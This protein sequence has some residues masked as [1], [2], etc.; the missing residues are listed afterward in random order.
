MRSTAQIELSENLFGNV[1]R[2][3]PSQR[4]DSSYEHVYANP[5]TIRA[6]TCNEREMEERKLSGL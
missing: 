5:E 6:Q 2:G 4:R 3:D 1:N